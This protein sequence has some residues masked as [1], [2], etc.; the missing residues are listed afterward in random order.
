MTCV[1]PLPPLASDRDEDW[2]KF[3]RDDPEWFLRAA[4]ELIRVFCGWHIYPNVTETVGKLT[5]GT[6][7]VIMLPSPH[8]TDVEQVTL[9]HGEHPHTLQPDEY[10]WHEAGW[11]ERKGQSYWN[12][13]WYRGV[14]RRLCR[15]A[16]R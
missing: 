11:I 16:D 2:A 8:V 14:A 6:R 12:D 9:Y 3:R 7:G 15:I 10:L 4:G 1:D 5:V 13:G